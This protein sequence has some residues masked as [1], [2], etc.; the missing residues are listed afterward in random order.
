MA[1]MPPPPSVPSPDN[2]HLVGTIEAMLAAMQ[3]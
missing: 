2:S 1:P 3:Q